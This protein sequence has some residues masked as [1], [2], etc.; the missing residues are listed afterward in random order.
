MICLQAMNWWMKPN[1]SELSCDSSRLTCLSIL[2]VIQ[3]S[4]KFWISNIRNAFGNT[5][6]H[7]G[8]C[9]GFGNLKIIVSIYLCFKLY[10][11]EVG[12]KL[13][14]VTLW[15][16]FSSSVLKRSGKF[17]IFLSLYF[18]KHVINSKL[19]YSFLL[20]LKMIFNC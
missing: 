14:E 10:L 19:L 6:F 12:N 13:C 7:R 17:L 18:Y 16:T 5:I 8:F 3:C 9:A 11:F 15:I 20:Q 4:L 1:Y 2:W